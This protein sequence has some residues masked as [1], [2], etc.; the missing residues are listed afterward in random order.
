MSDYDYPEW[1]YFNENRWHGP[2]STNKLKSLYFGKEIFES[3]KIVK[4][5]DIISQTND[6]VK[7]N[8]S[9]VKDLEQC[10][11]YQDTI[12][13]L[14]ILYEEKGDPTNWSKRSA[15]VP[16]LGYATLVFFLIFCGISSLPDNF[17]HLEL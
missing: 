13:K 4:H 14:N 10:D 12:A 7:E 3:T 15:I 1:Y 16:I 5:S 6:E 8:K 9:L 17:I 2:V 11:F